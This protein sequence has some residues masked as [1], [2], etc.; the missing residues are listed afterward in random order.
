ME[1][2]AAAQGGAIHTTQLEEMYKTY[3]TIGS[4]QL[5]TESNAAGHDTNKM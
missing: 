4:E 5:A 3:S 1:Q 2:E